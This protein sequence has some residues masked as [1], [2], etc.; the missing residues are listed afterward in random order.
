MVEEKK[1]TVF[2][3]CPVCKAVWT[4][5]LPT[6]AGQI[7]LVIYNMADTFFIG[8]T[9][10]DAML[11]AVTICMPAF[12]FLSAISNLFGI[13][14]AGMISRSLGKHNSAAA[15]AVS[16]L[17]IWGCLLLS[18]LYV[19]GVGVF[20]D[21]FIRLLGG[22]NEAVHAYAK[23]YLFCIVCV[24]GISASMSTMF[25]HL[26]RSEGLAFQASFGISMGGILNMILD[27]LFMFVLLPKGQEV[28]GAAIATG[29][30]NFAALVYYLI[31]V[32][33][34]KDSR[35]VITFRFSRVHLTEELV[36]GMFST[37]L[38]ACLMTLFENISYTVLDN[39]MAANGI[40]YQAGLGVA[41]KINMLAHCITRGISQGV[42]PMIGYNYSAGNV[43]RMR[44]TVTHSMLLC[45]GS[46]L[47][48]MVGSILLSRQL[49]SLFIQSGSEAIGHGSQFLRILCI[50]CPFSACAYAVISFFQ[51]VGCGRRSAVLA[52]LRKG[53]LD[54]PLMFL[55][56]NL[57]KGSGIVLATPIADAVCCGIAL[58]LFLHFNRQIR[59]FSRERL[60]T[61]EN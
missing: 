17:A 20:S 26:I 42:L 18:I 12:L 50:G 36:K 23:T 38:P 53:I 28:F 54:I 37:G 21:I 25:S 27:P 48:C 22:K 52:M 44:Q 30:S 5:A 1:Y 31:I 41:K 2:E 43:R 13:G 7:I 11:T 19:L 10:N 8:L 35:S 32:R 58:A 55:L 49:I 33:R 61:G 16:A 3:T 59:S 4:L 34:K 40:V 15:K 6:V 57:G 39:L 60:T 9:E 46:S 56:K 24:F 51:A 29:L 47:L 45:V 14:G